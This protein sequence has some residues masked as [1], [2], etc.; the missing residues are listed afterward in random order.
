MNVRAI[1]V[2]MEELVAMKSTPTTAPVWLDIQVQTV[3]V[4]CSFH[5]TIWELPL[6]FQSSYSRSQLL[7]YLVLRTVPVTNLWNISHESQTL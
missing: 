6:P 7:K 2:R 5:S 3:K 4:V 1:P